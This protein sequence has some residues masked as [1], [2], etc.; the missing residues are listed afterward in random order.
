MSGVAL[1]IGFSPMS[2]TIRKPA[3]TIATDLETIG[4]SLR[5][6]SRRSGFSRWQIQRWEHGAAPADPRF[7]S[8]LRELA[9]LHSRLSSP[10]ARAVPPPGNR[11]PLDGYGVTDALLT[12][13]WSERLL[14]K[15]LG[16][17]HTAL[18]RLIIR[19]ATFPARASRWLEALADGHRELPRPTR[20]ETT[21]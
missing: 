17:H 10:L 8:W 14:A 21:N 16:E 2:R 6:A 12:I 3:A 19:N 1:L 15:R 18:R 11:L 9:E 20:D 4:W 5:Q 7:R 13:G